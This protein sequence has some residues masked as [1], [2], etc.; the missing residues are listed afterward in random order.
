M[1]ARKEKFTAGGVQIK[2]HTEESANVA[3]TSNLGVTVVSAPVTL[4]FLL[5]ARARNACTSC[6]FTWAAVHLAPAG[7]A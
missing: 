4:L 1:L 5:S 3:F 6:S 7:A 2:E